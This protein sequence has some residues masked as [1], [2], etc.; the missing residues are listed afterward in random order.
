MIGRGVNVP[1]TSGLGASLGSYGPP[2]NFLEIFPLGDSVCQIKISSYLTESFVERASFD[3]CR[4]VVR[5]YTVRS[6]NWP[7][8]IDFPLPQTPLEC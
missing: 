7:Q 8:I 2:E 1:G 5:G 6:Q 4:R 3:I